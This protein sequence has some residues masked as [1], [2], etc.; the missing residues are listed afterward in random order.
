MGGTSTARPGGATTVA[1]IGVGRMGGGVARS[2]VRAGFSVTVYD[3]NARAV[4][5]CRAVG[6]AAAESAVEAADGA[7]V[8]VT[9]LPL[10][11]HVLDC[12]AELTPQLD[13]A[14]IAVD[15]STVDPATARAVADLV[16]PDR[17]VACLLGKGP[18]QAETG[19]VPVFVGG[20]DPALDRLGPMLEA[21]AE[22]VHRL[23]S[24][25]AATSFKLAS[26][27]IGMTA[28]AGLVEG[29][30]WCRRAGV[31]PGVFT[32]ALADTGGWST[33]AE[34][35]LHWMVDD[36]LE[37]RFAARLGAKDLRLAVAAAATLGVDAKVGAAT[38]AR[39]AA[40][41]DAGHGEDDVAAMI[42]TIGRP[43]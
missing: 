33:Q 4:A 37:A 10:P 2:L 35:R 41:E 40:T 26:N 7:N 32:A 23:G 9:S 38:L 16:G 1:V 24:I 13:A 3:P 43:A 17:F 42:R 36:D 22:R 5:R 28:L 21:I 25:E 27:L 15:T 31:D 12:W 19:S 30:E 29:F 20:P 6:A 34:V 14:V 11:Q 8:V 18:T 39:L